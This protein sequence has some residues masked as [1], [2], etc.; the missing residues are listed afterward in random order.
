MNRKQVS[1]LEVA[2]YD[3]RQGS[4]ECAASGADALSAV[5]GGCLYDPRDSIY[6]GAVSRVQVACSPGADV[7]S[8]IHLQLTA[9]GRGV[10]IGW[11]D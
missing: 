10:T 4:R 3:P 5:H 11:Q 1:A 8:N 2:P 6:P 9:R 7:G